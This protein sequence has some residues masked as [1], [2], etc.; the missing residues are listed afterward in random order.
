M[1][2][3]C[4]IQRSVLGDCGRLKGP[5]KRVGAP[6]S[7]RG[8]GGRGRPK[9]TV[10]PLRGFQPRVCLVI[11]LLSAECMTLLDV[12]S[13]LRDCEGDPSC[14]TLLQSVDEPTPARSASHPSGAGNLGGSRGDLLGIASIDHD[15]TAGLRQCERAAS[16]ETAARCSND[17]GAAGDAEVHGRSPFAIFTCGIQLQWDVG[18]IPMPIETRQF[19]TPNV[20][21]ARSGR[22]HAG[23]PRLVPPCQHCRQPQVDRPVY[24]ARHAFSRAAATRLRSAFCGPLDATASPSTVSVARSALGSGNKPSIRVKL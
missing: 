11:A 13:E 14:C 12:T 10:S 22:H 24:G 2:Q 3:D 16:S 6:P 4:H 8:L 18:G 1:S 9:R 23:V 20:A 15:L 21:A 19:S 7:S 5:V 17:G